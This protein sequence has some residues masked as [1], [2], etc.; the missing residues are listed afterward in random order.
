MKLDEILKTEYCEKFDELRKNRI[1][2]AYYNYGPAKQ[3][4]GNK[5]VDAIKTLKLQIKK[6]EETGNT[7]YLIDAA[8]Y[9]MFEF[10][11]PQHKKAHFRAT[12]SSE[13]AGLSGMS[14]NQIKEF[15]DQEDWD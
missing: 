3:N 14:Y 9:S 12:D 8:N 1:K 7:E 2:V 4:F 10:M 11:Y 5:L 13:S 6:Y 15:K